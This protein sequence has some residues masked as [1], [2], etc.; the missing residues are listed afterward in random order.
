MSLLRVENVTKTFGG[1]M[2]VNDVSLTVD[3]GEILGLI[4]PNGAGKTSLF[5]VV[6]GFLKPTAGSVYF[7]DE[8]IDRRTVAQICR[9]GLARTFQVVRPFGEMSVRDNVLVGAFVN[10]T[11]RAD[12][13]ARTVEV[14]T[15]LRMLE[16]AE[17]PA[18][19][20]TLAGRK[21]LELARVL[22]TRPKLLLVDEVMAG[23]NGAETA[24]MLGILSGLR[25]DGMAIIMVEHNMPA[26]LKVSDR[27]AVLHF[28]NKIADGSPAEIVTNQ[29]VIEAYIGKDHA[30]A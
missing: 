22:A 9:R 16:Q 8:R 29:T 21:R 17:Q 28:G 13:E 14:L 12:A 25:N 1:L 10:G 19:S 18:Q 2:A 23:L 24:E 7:E 4:G 26:V 15:H 30:D 20:L 11:S 27:V 6:A 3:A 5:N